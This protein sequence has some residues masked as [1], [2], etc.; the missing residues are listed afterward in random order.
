MHR[1]HQVA[2][3]PIV[4]RHCGCRAP[5]ASTTKGALLRR[6]EAREA[7]RFLE[8]YVGQGVLPSSCVCIQRRFSGA[9]RM[10]F[11]LLPIYVPSD[12][13]SRS[14]ITFARRSQRW[15]PSSPR[16]T[17]RRSSAF[18]RASSASPRRPS[19]ACSASSRRCSPSR[20]RTCAQGRVRG[21]AWCRAGQGDCAPPGVARPLTRDEYS[22]DGQ[23]SRVSG[24]RSLAGAGGEPVDPVLSLQ[25]NVMPTVE[26]LRSLGMVEVGRVITKQPAILSLSVTSNLQPKVAFLTSLG[27]DELPGGLGAQLDAYPA[28]LTLSLE[29]NLRPTAGR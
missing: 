9:M 2:R 12:F 7:V 6:G 21:L 8:G 17:S 22:P 3:G 28:L 11:L 19:A 16:I 18:S 27:L 1:A 4:A 23:L 14:S 26:Y 25:A 13:R 29:S 24:C 5:A 20:L 15:M 10:R